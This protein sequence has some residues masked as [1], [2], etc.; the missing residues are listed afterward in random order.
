MFVS[1]TPAYGRD[2]KNSTELLTD[3]QAGKDFRL[4]MP[5]GSTYF[6]IRDT[7]KDDEHW[8]V[9]FRFDKLNKTYYW[10]NGNARKH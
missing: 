3:W 9:T 2:Y 1:A 5:Q 10:D 6:S 4:H 8:V 7:E